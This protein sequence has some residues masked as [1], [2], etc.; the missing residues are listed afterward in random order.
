MTSCIDLFEEAVSLAPSATALILESGNSFSYEDLNS[1]ANK[2]ASALLPGCVSSKVDPSFNENGKNSSATPLVCIM[3]QRHMPLIASMLAVLKCGG[4]YV[5]V[6]PSFP[7]DRQL[8]IFSHSKCAVLLADEESFAQATSLGVDVPPSLIL[9]ASAGEIVL[10]TLRK[11]PSLEMS[12]PR[13]RSL[14][15]TRP[16]G[17]LMYVLYTSGSTGKPKGVM[18]RHHGVVNIISWFAKELSVTQSS[19][20]L[21]LTTSCFD[22]SV[23]EIFMPL[24]SGATLVLADSASQKNPFRLLDVIK[25]HRVSVLQATPTTFEMMLAAGWTGDKQIDVLVGGEAFRPSLF[26]LLGACRSIRNVYGP[27]ETTIWSSSYLMPSSA[28]SLGTVVPIGAPISRTDFYLLDVEIEASG[29]PPILHPTEGELLIGGVGV[30]EGYLNAPDL[31]AGRFIANPFG[32]GMVYRTGDLV[33]RLLPSGDYVFL[34]RL[35]D[36]VKIDGFRIELAEIENVYSKIPIVD[37][38]VAIVRENRLL[39]YVKLKKGAEDDWSERTEAEMHQLAARSL[40]HYMM[41]K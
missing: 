24:V 9:S 41:P 35:D 14:A 40:T 21:A 11:T 7:P 32:G 12:L 25:S 22:I 37:Q 19:R 38:S 36:Q 5:P 31:T 39:L 26:P 3:M 1:C 30:A 33:R 13:L 16:G 15:A 27:T 8:Y 6:D 23:L 34:R 4:G 28:A 17:G 10:S 18:V 29:G 20:V 2:I